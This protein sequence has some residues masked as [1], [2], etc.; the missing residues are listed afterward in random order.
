MRDSA[1]RGVL[2][3]ND[4]SRLADVASDVGG[5][6]ISQF[7]GWVVIIRLCAAITTPSITT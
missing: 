4:D 7:F 2:V 1:R 6:V 3:V 5:L